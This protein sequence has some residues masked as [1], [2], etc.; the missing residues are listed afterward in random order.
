M[1]LPRTVVVICLLTLIFM[2]WYF[3]KL[4]PSYWLEAEIKE[5]DA[6]EVW[7]LQHKGQ[8][9][10]FIRS[11]CCDQYDPVFSE[12]GEYICSPSGGMMGVG[13][14][15]CPLAPLADP[16]TEITRIWPESTAPGEKI[17][18]PPLNIRQTKRIDFPTE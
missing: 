11:G 1:T 3:W 16:G 10:Y 18:V 9:A 6:Q 13:D 2:S 15:K 17:V 5:Y 4:S 14:E 8:P 12:S 7:Q